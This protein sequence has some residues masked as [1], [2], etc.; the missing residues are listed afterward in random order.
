MLLIQLTKSFGWELPTHET[1]STHS[2][3]AKPAQTKIGIPVE[4]LLLTDMQ[5]AGGSVRYLPRV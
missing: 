1:H 3:Q 2:T 4:K 5:P